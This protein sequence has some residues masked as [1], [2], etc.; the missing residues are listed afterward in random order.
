M[1]SDTLE[2][3]REQSADLSVR[4]WSVSATALRDVVPSNAYKVHSPAFT[5]KVPALDNN[6][7]KVGLSNV[8]HIRVSMKKL[9]AWEARTRVLTT[10]SSHADFFASASFK[11]LQQEH[12]SPV[13]LS[14]LLEASGR[15]A[16]HAA[17]L[18]LSTACELLH[19]RRVGVLDTSK[20][21]TT[22]S[23]N[24]LNEAPLNAPELFVGLVDEV[25]KADVSEHQHRLMASAKPYSI[26]KLT[27][28]GSGF[29][30]NFRKAPAATQEHTR[31]NP[32][33]AAFRGRSQP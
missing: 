31:Y 4:E 17:A 32:M 33:A 8:S 18:S 22:T 5:I 3:I 13:A 7:S 19:L 30:N 24:T 12:F 26:P 6:A 9:E 27:S 23:K 14:R 20:V 15:A 1:V 2:L 29:K 11:L 28:S 25:C 10:I 16:R 21:L